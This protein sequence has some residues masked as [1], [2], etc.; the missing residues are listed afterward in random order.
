MSKIIH[1]RITMSLV[2]N[3]NCQITPKTSLSGK[4]ANSVM[5]SD[6]SKIETVYQ[7]DSLGGAGLPI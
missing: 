4:D 2:R 1:S 5:L 6:Y 3:K 7:D